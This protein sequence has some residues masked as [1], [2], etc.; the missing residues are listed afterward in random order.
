MKATPDSL[1]RSGRGRLWMPALAA[2]GLLCQLNAAEASDRHRTCSAEPTDGFIRYG[3]LMTCD[4]DPGTDLDGF[5]F[6]G[7]LG[8]AIVVKAT[9]LGGSGRPCLEILRPDGTTLEPKT[10][11]NTSIR[12]DTTLDQSGQY[13]IRVS[14]YYASYVMPYSLVIDRV[15]PASPVAL[16]LDRGTSTDGIVSPLGEIDAFTFEAEA[17]D[18]I[19]LVGTDTSA[20]SAYLRMELFDPSGALVT[21]AQN[22]AQASLNRTLTESGIYTVL[23]FEYYNTYPDMT[24][25]LD[26]SCSGVCPS[27]DL[28]RRYIDT[29]SVEDMNGNGSS[30]E[31]ALFQPLNVDQTRLLFKD[32]DNWATIKNFAV[33]YASVEPIAL[34][35]IGDSSGDL[36]SEL[37]ILGINLNNGGISVWTVDP[38]LEDVSARQYFNSD[39]SPLGFSEFKDL[40]GDGTA[41]VGV[42]AVEKA[43]GLTNLRVRDGVTGDFLVTRRLPQ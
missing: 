4:I 7:V 1:G 37:G 43:T 12:L 25:R 29:A 15:G 21:S 11:S 42:M 38:V 10:C 36:I 27:L 22:P 32:G 19:S 9:E 33:L 34:A 13:R 26:Y 18:A 5:R 41:D 3:D 31:V 17:G 30:E 2:L 28:T 24:Y 35:A 23:L 20:T 40:N 6:A 39:Y 8:E 16:Q 14:E